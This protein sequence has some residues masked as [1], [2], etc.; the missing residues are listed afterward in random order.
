[1]WTIVRKN[2]FSWNLWTSWGKFLPKFFSQN[3]QS[4]RDRA[5]LTYN[6]A[7]AAKSWRG[8]FF[9]AR[10]SIWKVTHF[11]SR[12]FFSEKSQNFRLIFEKFL[13]RGGCI[14]NISIPFLRLFAIY[15]L[16]I[17]SASAELIKKNF[18][19]AKFF[20]VKFFDFF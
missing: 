7:I 3:F 4:L 2:I 18:T 9:I 5:S 20:F 8:Y 11:W 17:L 13:G 10:D 6:I 19:V 16:S 15:R 12:N 14:F 1:M